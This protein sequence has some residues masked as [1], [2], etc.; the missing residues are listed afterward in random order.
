MYNLLNDTIS[1]KCVC[2]NKIKLRNF[3]QGYGSYCSQKCHYSNRRNILVSKG[4]SISLDGLEDFELYKRQVDLITKKQNLSSLKDFDKRGR[5]DLK[6]GAYHL[7]H[8]FS[9]AEGFKQNIPTYIIGDISNL[10]MIPATE[11]CIKQDDCSITIEELFERKLS[12][13]EYNIIVNFD[14]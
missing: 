14:K 3:I 12:K 13:K 5:S 6:S 9:K 10:E 4:L 1:P 2:G 7:D 8:K 11:N